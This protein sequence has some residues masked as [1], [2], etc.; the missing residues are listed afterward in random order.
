MWDP[1]WYMEPK[2]KYPESKMLPGRF[3]GFAHSVGDA[4]TFYVLTVSPSRSKQ[5]SVIARSVV[6][7]RMPGEKSYRALPHKP[8]VYYFPSDT[9]DSHPSVNVQEVQPKT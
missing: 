4:L 9:G 7:I 2:T 8:S 1:V 5:Q 6:I 3:M